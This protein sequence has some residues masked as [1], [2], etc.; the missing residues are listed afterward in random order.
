MKKHTPTL[1]LSLFV[2]SLAFLGCEE[3]ELPREGS[4][5]ASPPAQSATP[6]ESGR[7]RTSGGPRAAA[8]TR[9]ALPSAGDTDGFAP[10]APSQVVARPA[11]EAAER[12][13]Q[14]DVSGISDALAEVQG[15]L[16][17][18]SSLEPEGGAWVLRWRVENRAQEALY[19][20]THLPQFQGGVQ[21]PSAEKVYL[22]AQGET[23]QVSK[24]MWRVPS[25]LSPLIREVPF[26]TRLAPGQ[27]LSGELRLAATSRVSYPYRTNA[28][29]RATAPALVGAVQLSFGYFRA[30]AQPKVSS[31]DPGYFTVTAAA[32]DAQAFVTGEAHP[33]RLALR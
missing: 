2:S 1:I 21:V 15:P 30:D 20:C 31:S 10:A 8:P 24:L 13:R 7:A 17:L 29:R 19:L 23:L 9:E 25:G 18:E 11:G 33:A 22:R 16:A 32:I 28:E 4:R 6:R 12:G 3:R 27:S 5:S 26:L 14:R